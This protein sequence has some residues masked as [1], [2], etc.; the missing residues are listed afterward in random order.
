MQPPSDTMVMVVLNDGNLGDHSVHGTAT[1]T[2]YG[3]R[4]SGDKF[5]VASS[6]Q[7]SQPQKFVLD[8]PKAE[9]RKA[10]AP[11]PPPKPPFDFTELYGINEERAEKL[12]VMGVRSLNGLLALGK[13][14]LSEIVPEKTATRILSEAKEKLEEEKQ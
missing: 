13:E 2:F 3:Y 5:L 4:K 14:R 12:R 10:V 11:P 6:D 7:I 9:P 1:K 8:Q